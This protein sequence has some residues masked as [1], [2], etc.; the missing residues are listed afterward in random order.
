M[1]QDELRSLSWKGSAKAKRQE[2]TGREDFH[3]GVAL[4]L[5]DD[6]GDVV[7]IRDVRALNEAR[8]TEIPLAK[9]AA[10]HAVKRLGDRHGNSIIGWMTAID[11]PTVPS[12]VSAMHSA[13]FGQSPAILVMTNPRTRR[14]TSY[15]VSE[16]GFFLLSNKSIDDLGRPN[17]APTAP[18]VFAS[19]AVGMLVAFGVLLA[20]VVAGLV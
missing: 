11:A 15:D 10:S 9:N 7:I 12:D 14:A 6:D 20:L 19:V 17:D 13:L 4:L 5:G 2:L 8:I 16:R 1:S 18:S 3:A